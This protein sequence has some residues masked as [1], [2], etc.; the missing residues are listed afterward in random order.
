[1]VT[2]PIYV[3]QEDSDR[4]EN[5]VEVRTSFNDQRS[6]AH[7]PGTSIKGRNDVARGDSVASQLQSG[8]SIVTR[9]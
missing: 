9:F 1:M 3:E 8:G 6:E 5:I 2:N 7:G 4:E